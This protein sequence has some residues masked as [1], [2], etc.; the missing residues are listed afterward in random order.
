MVLYS[1]GW[2]VSGWDRLSPKMLGKARALNVYD[3]LVEGDATAMAATRGAPYDLIVSTDVFIYIGDLAAVFEACKSVLK[4][5]GTFAFSTET[6]EEVKEYE[7]RSSGRYAHTPDYIRDLARANGM[8]EISM[9][10]VALRYENGQPMHGNIFI[11]ENH[12]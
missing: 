7:L 6:A 9:D 8:T 2:L 4:P 12:E 1:A 11:F 5:G 10:A 3:D